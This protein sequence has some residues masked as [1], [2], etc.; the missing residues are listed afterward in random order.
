MSFL[1]YGEAIGSIKEALKI[2]TWFV[3]NILICEKQRSLLLAMLKAL[4]SVYPKAFGERVSNRNS[5]T[6]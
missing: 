2:L 1:S 4:A 3:P 6:A 5:K